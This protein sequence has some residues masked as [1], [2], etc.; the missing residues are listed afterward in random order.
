MELTDITTAQSE[1]DAALKEVVTDFMSN[2]EDITI[3]NIYFD[4]RSSDETVVKS[5]LTA[6]V[7]GSRVVITSNTTS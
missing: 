2:Y 3:S 7:D 6:T 4:L 5:T 1:L